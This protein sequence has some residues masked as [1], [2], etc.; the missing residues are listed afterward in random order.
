MQECEV[1]AVNPDAFLE[2]VDAR[3]TPPE[4]FS[5]VSAGAMKDE[6]QVS[7]VTHTKIPIVREK[8]I[9]GI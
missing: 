4:T 8:K 5:S 3:Y 9:H 6:L 7:E 1:L 2:L